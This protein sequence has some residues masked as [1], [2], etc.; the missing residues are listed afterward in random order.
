MISTAPFPLA[1]RRTLLLADGSFSQVEAKTAVCYL[2]YQG[3]DVV[4]VLDAEHAGATTQEVVGVGGDTPVV[5]T[6]ADALRYRPEVAIVGTAPMGGA[7]DGPLREQVVECLRAG[8]DVVSGLHTFLSD[9]DALDSLAKSNNS[10]IWDVRCVEGQQ[11]V[12][13]GEG[14]RTGASVV[15]VTGTDCNVGKM[16][17][18]V[19][20]DRGAGKR[21]LRSAWAATGQT[22]IM[23]RGR[24][25]A[26]DRVIS[27]FIG[28][29]TEELVNVE[30]EDADIVWV[31]GQGA[32]VHPGYAGVTLGLMYGAMPDAMVLAH[33][34]DREHF[35]RIDSLPLPPIPDLIRLHEQLMRP[36]K[37]ATV[38][39]IAVNTSSLDAPSARAYLDELSSETERVADDV[40]RFGSAAVLDAV[41]AALEVIK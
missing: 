28:G 11:S 12:S 20:L 29:A 15:L 19:A 35:K 3:D 32:I 26:V 40:V 25:V 34:A 18:A 39:A 10:R 21:G 37:P 1:G 4:A 16:T 8:A 31:E 24:G 36:F 22:G 30:G 13:T 2:M 17:A 14:C 41:L 38:A 27:D 7:L 23:L 33:T 9:D 6:I 5:A